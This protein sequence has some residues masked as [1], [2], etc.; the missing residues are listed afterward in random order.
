MSGKRQEII[1]KVRSLYKTYGIKSVTMDDV[2]HHLAISKKT[3]YQFFHDK[4]E[5]VKSVVECDFDK[6]SLN[7]KLDLPNLNAIEEV[8]QYYKM[9]INMIK[10]HKPSFI[11]DLKKYY[12][13]IFA[14][15]QKR[16]RE[17]IMNNTRSNIAKGIN[18]GLY[19]KN[20]DVEIIAKLNLMRIEGIM[21]GEFFTH[22]EMISEKLM[23]EIYIYHMYAIVND[24]GRE[25]FEKHLNDMINGENKF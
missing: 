1:E 7:M 17:R 15:I 11:Y 8:V 6:K 20:I 9:Q 18:E 3:L 10:D 13:E 22:E 12:P 24:A 2:A 4:D 19:R 16:M 5:L 25:L 14:N 21:S 23:S